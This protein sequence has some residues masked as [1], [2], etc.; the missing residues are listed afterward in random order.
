MLRTTDKKQQ[1]FFPPLLVQQTGASSV[2]HLRGSGGTSVGMGGPDHAAQ[3]SEILTKRQSN[4][5][6]NS[7]RWEEQ[8]EYSYNTWV[9]CVPEMS[10]GLSN[11]MAKIRAG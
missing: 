1:N 10:T 5:R 2:R 4:Q 9:R 11:S 7:L 8:N 6:E 3:G